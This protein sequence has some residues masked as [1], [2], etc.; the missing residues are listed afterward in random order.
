MNESQKVCAKA[1][2]DVSHTTEALGVE[3]KKQKDIKKQQKAV[4][5]L[6]FSYSFINLKMSRK[7]A[8]RI[9]ACAT[10]I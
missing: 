10:T 4:R 7:E 6:L 2:S 1:E 5:H 3:A 9:Y 8:L